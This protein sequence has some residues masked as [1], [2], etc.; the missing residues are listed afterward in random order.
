MYHA[1]TM[2]SIN[3]A[4]TL[5]LYYSDYTIIVGLPYRTSRM[6]NHFKTLLDLYS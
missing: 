5:V 1:G 4:T 2:T 3:V 6:N